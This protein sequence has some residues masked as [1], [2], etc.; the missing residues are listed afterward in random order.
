M[1]TRRDLASGQYNYA[2]IPACT[3]SSL[4]LDIDEKY[5]DVYAKYFSPFIEDLIAKKTIFTIKMYGP[6]TPCSTLHDNMRKAAIDNFKFLL[7]QKGYVYEEIFTER[8][9]NDVLEGRCCEGTKTIRII[10]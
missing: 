7:M 8:G 4:P 6:D 9:V 2:D 3:S 1:Y 10:N 5:R